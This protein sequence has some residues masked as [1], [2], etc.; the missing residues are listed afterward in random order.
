MSLRVRNFYI[1]HDDVLIKNGSHLSR[2]RLI[3]ID[4]QRLTAVVGVQIPQNVS[5]RIEQ[6]SV[7]ATT[8]RQIA[9][10]IGYHAIQP[11]NPVAAGQR[12][13]SAGPKIV[14]ATTRNQRLEFA[15]HVTEVGSSFHPLRR[16]S[17]RAQ[18]VV[19]CG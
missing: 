14:Y 2:L 12:N 7:H 19:L 3:G 4:Q 10:V 1:I 16:S 18:T 17:R 9:D 11:S 5:L 13:L 15:R 8:R 6:K